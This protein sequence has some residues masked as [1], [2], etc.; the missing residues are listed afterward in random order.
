MR[1][2]VAPRAARGCR[3]VFAAAY[4]GNFWAN[5]HG[6]E[7]HST[8]M[9]ARLRLGGRDERDPAKAHLFF[10]P[11][12]TRNMCIAWG[13]RVFRQCDAGEPPAM[14]DVAGM[15]RWLLA[16]PQFASSDGSDHFMVIEPPWDHFE[17]VVRRLQEPETELKKL[18][19]YM[20]RQDIRKK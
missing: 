3:R 7:S 6:G 12:M 9:Q 1:R 4:Q 2:C 20:N 10:V 5:H 18:K 8:V 15:W 17:R 14:R 19:P 13:V 16:Q 11:F